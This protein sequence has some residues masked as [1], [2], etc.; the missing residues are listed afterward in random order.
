M[1]L[2]S[3]Y[4]PPVWRWPEIPSPQ[5]FFNDLDLGSIIAAQVFPK[6]NNITGRDSRDCWWPSRSNHAQ[7]RSGL[8]DEQ[9][10]S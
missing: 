3:F 6:S 5:I 8:K 9:A 4:L 7:S 10:A 2:V 1:F